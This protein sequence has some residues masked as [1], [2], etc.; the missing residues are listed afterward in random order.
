MPGHDIFISYSRDDRERIRVLARALEA[1]GWRVWWDTNLLPGETFDRVICAAL[2]AAKVVIVAWSKVSV[3]RDWVLNE[4][5][6]GRRRNILVPVLI[7]RVDVPLGFRR[8]QCANLTE[9]NG[10][11]DHPEL[12]SLFT[13]IEAMVGTPAAATAPAVAQPRRARMSSRNILYAVVALVAVLLVG[14]ASLGKWLPDPQPVIP[15]VV[16]IPAG[17]FTMG[18]VEGDRSPNADKA[19]APRHKVTIA[20]PFLMGRYEV[21]VA[22]YAEFVRE[23]GQEV[24]GVACQDVDFRSGAYHPQPNMSWKTPPIFTQGEDHPVIC[25]SWYDAKSYLTWLSH[26][27]GQRYRLPSEAEWEYAARAGV[28][29]IWLWGSDQEAKDSCVL[30]NAADEA[31]KRRT[32]FRWAFNA[33]DDD[34]P[35]TAPVGS[36][37]R[38]AFG[39]YDMIG[40]AW[41]WVE[42]CYVGG[43]EGAPDNGSARSS[44]NC[45]Q[46]GLRGAG[47]LSSPTDTRLSARG[48]ND[49]KGRYYSV[50]FRVV[51]DE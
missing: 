40:N 10:E 42:D 23:Q 9:W 30:T 44:D 51:R 25:V 18:G 4:A 48:K 16:M 31:W 14:A 15:D 11:P 13:R 33:C 27:T 2:E 19:E 28:S 7:D 8:L 5:D 37:Q 29:T 32:E 49:P 35:F 26:K 24:K 39:L 50:G 43:Y 34:Y 20:K 46:R 38:N 22:Q 1:R 12:L 45:E 17:E 41:E 47:W 3:D 21:T 36:F 6:E